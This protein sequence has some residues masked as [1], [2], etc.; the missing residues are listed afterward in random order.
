MVAPPA[1]ATAVD[2]AEEL[3]FGLEVADRAG[4]VLMD[5]YERLERIDHKSARDVVT[6]ADHLS[7]A[8]ILEAIRAHYPADAILAE[9]TGEH[10][11]KAGEALFFPDAGKPEPAS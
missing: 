5:R 4:A 7:E 1:T 10:K 3:A 6:E 8:L 9:E 11:A 2:F